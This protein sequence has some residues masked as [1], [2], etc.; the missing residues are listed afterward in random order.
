MAKPVAQQ[1]RVR[2]AEV[3]RLGTYIGAFELVVWSAL[4][5]VPVSLV[6]GGQAHDINQ[7]FW[8][9][10]EKVST[11]LPCH[12]FVAC[13]I[14]HKRQLLAVD[15][16]E[17]RPRFG[18]YVVGTRVSTGEVVSSIGPVRGTDSLRAV[19]LRLGLAS[20]QIGCVY[21]GACR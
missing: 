2:A 9:D 15:T 17:L 10:Y 7:L 8:S 14:G 19:C 20:C 16:F 21:A 4:E 6:V 11:E 13:N 12:Y 5:Q 1:I 3:A 18:H